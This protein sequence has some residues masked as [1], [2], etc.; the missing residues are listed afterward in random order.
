VVVD[1]GEGASELLADHGIDL[2]A[3][4]TA[5]DLLGEE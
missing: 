3:L 2:D 1:R 5:D 4:L